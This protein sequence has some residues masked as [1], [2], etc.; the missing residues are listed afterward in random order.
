VTLPLGV[1]KRGSV[2]FTPPL[3]ARKQQAINALGMGVL[4][5]V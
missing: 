1:L 4:D 5:K 2:Q 3:P